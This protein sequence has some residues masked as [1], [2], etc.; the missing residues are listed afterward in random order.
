MTNG[1][2]QACLF[3]QLRSINKDDPQSQ[4]YLCITVDLTYNIVVLL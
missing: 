2:A 4:H 1:S 3:T